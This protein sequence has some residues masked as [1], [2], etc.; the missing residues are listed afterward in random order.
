MSEGEMRAHH[1]PGAAWRWLRRSTQAIAIVAIVLA[2]FLGGWQRLDRSRM[3]NWDGHGWDLPNWVMQRLEVGDASR[4]A[5]EWNRMLGGGTSV[6][7]VGV[8]IVDPVAGTLVLTSTL[9]PTLLVLVAWL[10]PVV[11]GVVAGR[12]FCGWFCPYGTLARGL[13]ALLL[14][15]A[16]RW[17]RARIPRRR[18]LRYVILITALVVGATGTQWLLYTLLPHA[19]VQQSVY[20]MWLM[21]GGGAALGSLLG[22]IAVSLVFGPTSYCALVCPTGAALALLG[23]GRVV[24]LAVV[25]PSRCAKSCDLCDRACWLDLRPSMNP[26]ADCDLCTRCTE[27]CPHHNLAI[28]SGKRPTA[29]GRAML[30]LAVVG[31]LLGCG[32]DRPWKDHPQLLLDGKVEQDGAELFVAV[33]DQHDVRLDADDV[34]RVGGTDLAIYVVRGPKSE[35]DEVGKLSGREVYRGPLV[36]HLVGADGEAL[37]ELALEQP[38]APVS[39]GWRT[40]YQVRVSA[41]PQAG[42]RIVVE[43]IAGWTRDPVIVVIPPPNQ[44]TSSWRLLELS[45]A[46]FAL[47]GGMVALAIGFARA[48]ET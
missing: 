30:S 11:L 17:P 48:E 14:R 12:V 19:L 29:L 40:V 15:V 25:A 8:P 43:P 27:V 28:V 46:G 1:R 4:S 34:E 42:D 23:R 5:Y 26:G 18:G 33:V 21:G 24:H 16:P 9:E 3:A 32:D 2:P 45:V 35:P 7:Y 10:L 41:R 47:F 20:G 39:V 36:A 31:G 44:A 37:G 22:L 6:D 38:N 13:D